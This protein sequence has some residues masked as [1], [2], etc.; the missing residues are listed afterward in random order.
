MSR[1]VTLPPA[2]VEAMRR[3]QQRISAAGTATEHEIGVSE[4]LKDALTDMLAAH[5]ET[6]NE[7]R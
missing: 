5:I 2:T 3:I 4:G 1:G 6:Q 7:P